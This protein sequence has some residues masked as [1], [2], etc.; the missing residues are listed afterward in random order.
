MSKNYSDLYYIGVVNYVSLCP[1]GD[2]YNF[3]D[4]IGY[5]SGRTTMQLHY[6][7]IFI[8]II[9]KRCSIKFLTSSSINLIAKLEKSL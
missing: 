5:T 4:K 8:L 2:N 1:S 3:I 6:K 9:S 7:L